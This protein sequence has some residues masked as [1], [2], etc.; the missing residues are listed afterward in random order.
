MISI[1]AI[2]SI[3]VLISVNADLKTFLSESDML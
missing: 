2:Y 1:S 3:I